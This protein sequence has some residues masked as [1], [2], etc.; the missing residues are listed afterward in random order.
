MCLKS[1]IEFQLSVLLQIM[2]LLEDESMT[3]EDCGIE[4]NQSILIE[5]RFN[6]NVG[7]HK[8]YVVLV[9][10]VPQKYYKIIM[11]KTL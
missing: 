1:C 9:I 11:Y 8:L 6:L 5:G 7:L 3:V 10:G 2:T 4:E